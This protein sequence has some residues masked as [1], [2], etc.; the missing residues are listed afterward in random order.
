MTRLEEIKDWIMRYAKY[1]NVQL[2][3][4]GLIVV[5]AVMLGIFFSTN[6]KEAV[7]TSGLIVT[8][9]QGYLQEAENRLEKNRYQDVNAV[10]GKYYE[11][12]AETSDFVDE[13]DDLTI[14]TKRGRYEGTY[15]VFVT[16]QMSIP[17][18]Y[19]KAP[20]LE[21]LYVYKDAEDKLCISTDVSTE[22]LK[23]LAED[24]TGHKDVQALFKGVEKEYQKAVKSDAMLAEAL[25]DLNS[26]LDGQDE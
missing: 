23:G 11:R 15:L 3:I 8:E 21:T 24:L 20:G 26:A 5:L 10:I 18:I 12:Q 14:Y 7:A 17:G 6:D 2:A 19:T 16:Y 25:A 9:N 1:Y 4:G 22:Q 13:F